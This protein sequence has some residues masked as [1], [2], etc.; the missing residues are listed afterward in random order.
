MDP[1]D[2][3]LGAKVKAANL[4]LYY[5]SDLEKIGQARDKVTRPPKADDLCT[6]CYS[7]GTTGLPVPMVII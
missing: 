6:I 1:I 4:T 7:S 2:E 3:E 5:I